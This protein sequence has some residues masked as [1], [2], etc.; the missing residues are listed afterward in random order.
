[1]NAEVAA[2]LE[3]ARRSLVRARRDHEED[4]HDFAVSGAYYAMFYAAEALLASRGLTFSRHSGVIAAINREFVHAG[5]LDHA[6][7]EALQAAFRERN[8]VD[9]GH[10]P[11]VSPETAREILA[12]ADA[13][14]RAANA[15][16]APGT[17]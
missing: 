3:K 13:F 7:F 16:L 11:S 9:Y 10:E 1:M 4:D 2:R 17:T 6:H 12:R 8:T 5:S 15:M 14:L